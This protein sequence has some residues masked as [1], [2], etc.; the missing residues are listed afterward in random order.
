MDNNF[1]YRNLPLNMDTVSK[2]LRYTVLSKEH[3]KN[4]ITVANNRAEYFS[5]RS[6][7][8][9]KKS[10]EAC[11][12][13]EY[14][15]EQN[16]NLTQEDIL[17]VRKAL[18]SQINEKQDCGDYALK[19]DIPTRVGQ[20]ENDKQYVRDGE[21]QEAHTD[22]LEEI[23][24]PEK[25]GNAGK[26]LYNDGTSLSWIRPS[27][28]KMFE[29]KIFDHILSYE[30][31]K[32]YAL[33]GTYVYKNAVAGEH[34]GYPDFYNKCLAE[35]NAG[36]PT[37]TTLGS[38]TITTYNNLNGHIYYNIADKA[39]VD[40]YYE[41]NGIA[42]MYGVDETN[43]RI[44]LP[45]GFDINVNK[46]LLL[47]Y[48]APISDTAS[49]TATWWEIYSDGW[50]RQG[51]FVTSNTVTFKYPMKNTGYIGNVTSNCSSNPASGHDYFYNK[52]TTGCNLQIIA[53]NGSAIWWVEGEM[54]SIP[55][56]IVSKLKINKYLYYIVGNT[57]QDTSWIDVVT[58]VNGGVQELND[59]TEE[60]IARLQ[61]ASNALTTNQITNCF[62]AMPQRINYTIENGVLTIK[63]GSVVIVPYGTEDKSAQFPVGSTFINSN[64]TVY[65]REFKDSKFF[66]WAK[67]VNDL[68]LTNT[69]ATGTVVHTMCLN[70][71]VNSAS[72]GGIT[73]SGTDYTNYSG[74][75]YH[76][77]NNEI[78]Y[79][80]NGIWSQYPLSFPI[81]IF[82][83]VGNS[84]TK[85]N[86]VFNGTG[87]I[88]ST[89][90]LDKGVKGLAANGRNTDGT[91]NNI[92]IETDRLYL[93]TTNNTSHFNNLWLRKMNNTWSL[94]NYYADYFHTI[95]NRAEL[96]DA[97]SKDYQVYYIEEEAKWLFNNNWSVWQE[98]PSVVFGNNYVDANSLITNFNPK[99]IFQALNYN[100]KS[101]IADWGMPS[102]NSINLTAGASGTQYTAPAAGWFTARVKTTGS[103]AQLWFDNTSSGL[104][105]FQTVQPNDWLIAL[106]IPAKKGQKVSLLYTSCNVEMFK[107]VYASGEVQ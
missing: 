31:S 55:S 33:Q 37:Q 19:N 39:T 40:A 2:Y 60:G 68:S 97:A 17:K 22:M 57:E 27:L 105:I 58:E 86:K 9:A 81:L 77:T 8:S 64:Y 98:T 14:Y 36:V 103:N 59:A 21:M 50:I 65:D 43:Q 84:F 88:G 83:A 42:N 63:A 89:V 106:Y 80:S 3:I 46:R 41:A 6:E 7:K 72:F 24:M 79:V 85:V 74:Q 107:F 30:E 35:K 49:T 10:K 48:Q 82:T 34:Y 102:S 101:D 78:A 5:R 53:Q 44:F 75:Y 28:L 32:G 91:I 67:L 56:E 87:Y 52:K 90:W 4:I 47:S 15:S 38:S 73:K 61:A 66:V 92:A 29:L 99:D 93:L 26:F 18:E 71:S 45:R 62:T 13:S 96:P 69:Y 25:S 12:L 51:G 70:L 76:T 95:N 100:D 20:L 1:D 23:G 54:A 94:S 104:Q 11:E 16:T